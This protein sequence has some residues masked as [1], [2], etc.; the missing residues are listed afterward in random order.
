MQMKIEFKNRYLESTTKPLF[1]GILNITPD[2]FSDGGRNLDIETALQ[3]AGNMLQAGAEIIDIG[4]ESTRPG[5]Q[6]VNTEEELKRVIPVIEELRRSYPECVI[7]IDTT[8]VQVAKTAIEVGAD[9]INDISGL[10]F[11]TDL[12]EIA[13]ETGAGLILMHMR[14]T[15]QTMQNKANLQYNNLMD[16]IVSFLDSAVRKAVDA[17]VSEN[18]IMIDP[19]IGFSKKDKQNLEILGKINRL[20]MLHKPILVGPSRKSFI[21]SLLNENDPLKREWGTAGVVAWL[22][23]NEIDIIRIHSIKEML[24]MVE[25]LKVCRSYSDS[26]EE[27][28]I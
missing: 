6:P 8:K 27:Y 15:P 16:E 5:A 13:A 11:T 10:Q 21:G 18:S 26:S 22:V 1:M 20:K 12:A 4:G 7:S 3:H 19:G 2:S 28:P 24:Q 25:L 14:G 9:I 17:G 23:M